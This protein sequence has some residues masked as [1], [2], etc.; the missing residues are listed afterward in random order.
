MDAAIEPLTDPV[1]LVRQLDATALRKRI[2]D[3]DHE[4]AALLI[5]LRA[6][7]RAHRDSIAAQ[8]KEGRC[9]D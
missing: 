5:L 1:T 6:A 2:D 9:H 8:H 4:R 3:L 7:Q